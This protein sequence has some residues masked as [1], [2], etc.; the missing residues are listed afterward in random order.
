M[1]DIIKGK[2]FRF[3]VF[4][5]LICSIIGKILSK[6]SFFSLVG[7]LV[8]ALIL[9]MLFQ[10][11]MNKN[12]SDI[13][14]EGN[15]FISNKFLRLGII[16]LGFK[17][18]LKEL[19]SE[20]IKGLF[21]AIFIITLGIII[22]YYIFSYF[23]IDHTLALLTACGCSICGAAAVMGV[24]PI[25]KAKKDETILSIATV[26]LLG[27]V[28]TVIY[29]FIY[30]YIG[31]TENQFGVFA[32]ASLHEIAHAVAA[33]SAIGLDSEKIAVITK[34][35]RVLMLV[36]VSFVFGYITHKKSNSNEKSKITIPW[37][38]VGFLI[39]SILGAF[40]YKGI[41]D[42]IVKLSYYLLA[43]AMAA[44]GMNVNYTII[45]EKGIKL[46]SLAFLG[47]VILSIISFVISKI[48][49]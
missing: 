49:F 8:L 47:S 32:G 9:G 40:I 14:K 28:F 29:I 4:I 19:F 16:L 15:S 11:I 10:I 44:L 13:L 34:L 20:G 12:F 37:F 43:M 3:A 45:K 5:T 17:L 36:P 31:L 25:V 7:H 41:T 23:K 27:T 1:L 6:Y 48:F 46:I 39:A 22:F 24:A 30:K 42:Q 35:S 2:S 21:V 33:G 18:D 38:M 26:C